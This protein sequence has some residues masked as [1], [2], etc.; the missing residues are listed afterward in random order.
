MS[1]TPEMLEM[2]HPAIATNA[3]DATSAASTTDARV[4]PNTAGTTAATH[5]PP[6]DHAEA[7]EQCEYVAST[8]GA[9]T[10]MVRKPSAEE[11]ERGVQESAVVL[12]AFVKRLGTAGV[13]LNFGDDVALFVADPV[14]PSR[15]VRMWHG[16]AERGQFIGDTFTPEVVSA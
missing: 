5:E 4:A 2:L 7:E 16:R 12:Q 14:D 3:A 6:V 9:V 10:V 1:N 13:K 15:V 11:V 8:C